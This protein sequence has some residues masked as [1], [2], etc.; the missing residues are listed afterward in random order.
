MRYSLTALTLA[1]LA[2]GASF[3]AEFGRDGNE[4]AVVTATSAVAACLF[5][6]HSLLNLPDRS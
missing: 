6:F 1:L 4:L 2:I 5:A 3:G